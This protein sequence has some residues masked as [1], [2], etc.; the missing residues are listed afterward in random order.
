MSKNRKMVVTADNVNKA[1]A[2]IVKFCNQYKD[3]FNCP[4]WERGPVGHC[5]FRAFPNEWGV[6]MKEVCGDEREYNK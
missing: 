2:V 1:A 6:Q 4:A 5:M 3:C